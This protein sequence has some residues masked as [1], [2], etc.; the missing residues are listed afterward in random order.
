METPNK[1]PHFLVDLIAYISLSNEKLRLKCY[2][3]NLFKNNR[4][5]RRIEPGYST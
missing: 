4:S 1:I 3:F 2:V 5:D